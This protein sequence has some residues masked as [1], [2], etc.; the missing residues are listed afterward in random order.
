MTADAAV[1]RS[2]RRGKQRRHQSDVA[3][4]HEVPLTYLKSIE[5]AVVFDG[6]HVIVNGEDVAVSGEQMSDVQRFRL[7]THTHITT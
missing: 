6:E 5:R 1:Q 2:E 3:K 7:V 4:T